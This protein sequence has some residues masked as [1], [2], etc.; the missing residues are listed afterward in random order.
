MIWICYTF[1]ACPL[2]PVFL[3]WKKTVGE[4]I[5]FRGDAFWSVNP[6]TILGITPSEQVVLR[7]VRV[8]IDEMCLL[9]T[10]MDGKILE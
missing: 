10:V 2:P 5:S 1:P 9:A 6:E 8:C 7:E 3:S 4:M